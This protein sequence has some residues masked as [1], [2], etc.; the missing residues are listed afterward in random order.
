MRRLTWCLL[1]LLEGCSPIRPTLTSAV[2]PAAPVSAATLPADLGSCRAGPDG[3]PNAPAPDQI[4]DRGIGG[5]GI[6]A[7]PAPAPM[8]EADRG[9]GGTGIVGVVTGFASI[10]LSGREVAFANDV[11]VIMDGAPASPA[12]LRAGQLT[13]VEAAGAADALRARR[14]VIRHEVSGPVEEVGA[15][16]VLRV[17]GQRVIV[18]AQ[19]WGAVPVKV[20]DWL[21]VSG[22]RALGG[23]IVATR[24]D[25]RAPGEVLVHG[26]L[27][28]EGRVLRIGALEVRPATGVASGLIVTPGAIVTAVGRYS[29]GILYAD[30]LDPDLLL[31]D[32]V[33]YFGPG[34]DSFVVEGY[35]TLV[36]GRL[37]LGPRLDLRAPGGIEGFAP[38]RAV[39]EFRRA[40]DGS[41][42]VTSLRQGGMPPGSARDLMA[43]RQSERFEPA[44]TPDHRFD[45]RGGARGGQTGRDMRRVGQ[46]SQRTGAE[47]P[48]Q[49]GANDPSG[50]P[51]NGPNGFNGA[52]SPGP[53]SG[54]GF[55]DP[56]DAGF[57][58]R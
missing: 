6:R 17:A 5:T 36:G 25:R 18:G 47:P 51:F 46:S 23:E 22:L 35:A 54:P 16:G 41:L 3:E 56:G 31:I 33:G 57:R 27:L 48:P 40:G 28:R 24:I 19:T 12:T 32:P 37:R 1:A 2:P 13:A 8:L 52:T 15:D 44:P 45:G 38:S 34:V 21:A 14:I 7:A 20:G 26:L 11:P 9:I 30:T 53:G 50:A 39:A 4:A 10:C 49:N 42:A 58:R 43:P 55:G 29:D